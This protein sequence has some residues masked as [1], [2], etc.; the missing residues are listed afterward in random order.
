M[1]TFSHSISRSSFRFNLTLLEGRP[2]GKQF[3]FLR[4]WNLLILF[5]H[6]QH[7]SDLFACFTGQWKP[8]GT[9]NCFQLYIC[10]IVPRCQKLKENWISFEIFN[11][12]RNE[13]HT[14]IRGWVGKNQV[15]KFLVALALLKKM[16]I[17]FMGNAIKI[18]KKFLYPERIQ[19]LS[20]EGKNIVY[21]I[22]STKT[23]I[24]FNVLVDENMVTLSLTLRIKP[25]FYC[26]MRVMKNTE[27]GVLL[28]GW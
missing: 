12:V 18:L 7:R 1:A 4:N 11:K 10:F 22:F 14:G 26:F 9:K 19:K 17:L 27:D 21:L 23:T 8:F 28:H 25:L 13:Q 5:F 16:L 3:L 24:L 20:V 6:D 2:G 15:H